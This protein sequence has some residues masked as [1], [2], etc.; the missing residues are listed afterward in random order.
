MR[1]EKTFDFGH[2]Y[3]PCTVKPSNI[4]IE[5]AVSWQELYRDEKKILLIT[6]NL[7]DWDFFDGSYAML[8]GEKTVTWKESDIRNKLNTVLYKKMFT[9]QERKIILK[10]E[11]IQEADPEAGIEKIVTKDYLFLLSA[12]EVKEYLT[13][14]QANA[15]M[16][17]VDAFRSKISIDRFCCAWWLR[18]PGRFPDTMCVVEN[19]DIDDRGM[20]IDADEVGIRPAMWVDREKF[21]DYQ[22][23]ISGGN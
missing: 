16:I 2:W 14:E 11:V 15:E 10:S 22:K 6:E 8:E 13:E 9:D 19:G 7:I 1:A 5:I 4:L 23:K 18:T 21:E 12:K 20:F 3:F 17:L